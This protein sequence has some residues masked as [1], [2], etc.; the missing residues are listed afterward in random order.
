MSL[1]ALMAACGGAQSGGGATQA[2]AGN[3]TLS[4]A[5]T[6]APAAYAAV[7]V[8]V[9]KVRVHVDTDAGSGQGGWHEV[10]LPSPRRIDLLSLANGQTLDLG[11]IDLPAGHYRQIRL[12][13]A[14]NGSGAA[15]MTNS[16]RLDDASGTELS[17]STPSAQSSGLKVKGEFDVV[18]GQPTHLVLDF[19]AHRSVVRAGNSGR[20][21]LKPVISALQV[22]D[23]GA[24]E[25]DGAIGVA[26]AWV[27]AQIVGDDGAVQVLKATVS[28]AN[29]EF[30]LAPLPSTTSGR[31][32]L[33]IDAPGYR[34]HVI[35]E[36][37]ALAGTPTVLPTIAP[38]NAVAPD[39]HDISGT[40]S[41][42]AGLEDKLLQVTVQ[43]QVDGQPIRIAETNVAQT[44]FD[45]QV[46][47]AREV[48][49]VADYDAAGLSFADPLDAAA[50]EP[51]RVIVTDA[52]GVLT[53]DETTVGLPATPGASL[54][55][56]D[57]QMLSP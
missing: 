8:T 35:R 24:L 21:N 20:Y 5:L 27:S 41:V 7:N 40:V 15:A 57:L 56:V 6:D 3:G 31:Y 28:D 50:A 30:K 19:D 12:V 1:A 18:A 54:T 37:P 38:G 36:V 22:A 47:V 34:T 4:V 44:T 16:V 46:S 2:G 25:I 48:P 43:R 23:Q 11:S 17:L 55:G 14:A 51:Y 52:D 53:G 32:T 42:P 39:R 33:V 9:V 13:L 26:D 49:L 29:G 45:Y 10:V